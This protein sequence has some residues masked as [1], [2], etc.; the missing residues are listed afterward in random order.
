MNPCFGK[1]GHSCV[2]ASVP[3]QRAKSN[4]AH[5]LLDITI[6]RHACKSF[7]ERERG[8]NR[9]PHQLADTPQRGGRKVASIRFTPECCKSD[10]GPR[11]QASQKR[12]V[13]LS[14]A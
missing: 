2:T 6:S 13:A 14:Q 1:A 9:S 4:A 12:I 7:T 10:T 3:R 8:P 5:V 11:R